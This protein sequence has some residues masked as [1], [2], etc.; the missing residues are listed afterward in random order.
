MPDKT[1]IAGNLVS[2]N[3]IFV[4][5]TADNTGIGTTNPTSKLT[6]I[7]DGLFT[8]IVTAASFVGSGRSLTDV[9]IGI[10][11]GGNSIGF[12]GTVNFTGLGVSSVTVSSGIATINIPGTDRKIYKFTAT[13]GQTS[14]SIPYGV[15]PVRSSF[16]DVFLNGV[17]L[18]TSQYVLPGST[19]ELVAGTSINDIVEIIV[20][21][22]FDI[23]N[24]FNVTDYAVTAGLAYSLSPVASINTIGIITATGFSGDRANFNSLNVSGVT[25]SIGGFVGDFN[26]SGIST[27][28]TLFGNSLSYTTANISTGI[29]TNLSGINL[30]YSGIATVGFLTSNNGYFSGI[31]TANSFR[32]SSG[33]IQAADGTNA[34]YIYDGTGNVAFQGTIGASQINNASGYKAI[35]LGSTTTPS[36]VVSNNLN[37][38]S[39]GTIFTTFNNNI[40]IGTTTPSTKLTVI[41]DSNITGIV[42]ATSYYGKLK[43]NVK[44]ISTNY[45]VQTSDSV[46]LAS[47]SITVTMP[48]S[49]GFLGDKYYVKNVGVGTIRIIPQINELIDDYSEL[50]LGE[51][52]S[53]LTLISDNSKWLIF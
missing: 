39:G 31:V 11:S 6:V 53:S 1:R 37:V 16:I 10:S 35:E 15:L 2:D 7:G 26:S 50:I 46:I 30:S 9:R 48:T 33:Y 14:F 44:T 42:S 24:Y 52:N 21:D 34:F 36:V 5:P 45:A 13:E 4:N 20:Y 12:A 22:A 38:G 49:I 25:T 41:G 43:E 27:A 18:S 19:V 40:G 51:T 32:P 8:G 47:G 3:N 23:I 17:K 29:V 28:N